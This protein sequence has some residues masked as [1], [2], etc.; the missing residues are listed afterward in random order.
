M[1]RHSL[2]VTLLLVGVAIGL[3]ESSRAETIKATDLGDRCLGAGKCLVGEVELGNAVPSFGLI[4]APMYSYTSSDRLPAPTHAY[5]SL[6]GLTANRIRLEGAKPK[7]WCIH[8]CG[9]EVPEPTSIILA[10]TG[11]VGLI[12]KTRYRRL[13]RRETR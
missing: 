4:S 3:S 13:F 11:L 7:G 5:S 6:D 9:T 2:C 1:R 8:N 10:A 12:V